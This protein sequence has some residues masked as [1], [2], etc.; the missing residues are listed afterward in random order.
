MTSTIAGQ[1][2]ALLNIDHDGSN[3]SIRVDLKGTVE[4]I[5]EPD[6]VAPVVDNDQPTITTPTPGGL[7]SPDFLNTKLNNANPK[8]PTSLQFGPDGNLYV[9]E[10]DGYIW[11]YEVTRTNTNTYA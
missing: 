5:P 3:P 2:S 8:N 11:E 4:L 6:P 7:T 10:R 9:A 1:K